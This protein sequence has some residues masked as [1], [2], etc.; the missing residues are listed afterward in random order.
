M[1]SIYVAFLIG[2]VASTSFGEE[3][4]LVLSA[5]KDNFGRS[6]K[7]NRNNGANELLAIA[8][9]PN[10]RTIIAFDLSSVTNEIVGAEL[11]FRQHN[12]MDEKTSLIVAPMV[13]T[14]N[15]V[16]WGEGVGNLGAGGQNARPGESCYAYSAFRDVPWESATGE[17]LPWLN[18]ARLWLAPVA[19]LNGLKWEADRWIR[20]PIK[21]IALLEKIRNSE[22]PM[23]TLGLWG[24]AGNGLYFISS[25]NSQ[26]SPEL[27]LTL[28]KDEKK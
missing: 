13:N 9:A 6:N 27:Q 10:I 14:T 22:T 8:H 24:T 19:T 20:V 28:Q 4:L 5:S 7:R 12:A 1:K 17:P 15:N 2:C 11:R 3:G 23:I 16:A 18:D 21:D 25:K 26:W